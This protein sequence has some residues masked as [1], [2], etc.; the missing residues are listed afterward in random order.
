MQFLELLTFY[1]WAII[2]F[3]FFLLRLFKLDGISIPGTFAGVMMAVVTFIDPDIYW[4]WQVWG[5]V[6]LTAVT[7]I[8]YL[9]Q[10][11]R[12]REQ[13]RDA[14]PTV[15][16]KAAFMVGTTVTLEQPL[17]S[18]IGKLLING[19]YWRVT[20]N[21]DYPAGTIVVV[22][23]HQGAVLTVVTAENPSY[24]ISTHHATGAHKPVSEYQRDTDVESEYGRPDFDAWVLFEAALKAHSK[25]SLVAAYYLL[26]AVRGR[27]LTQARRGLNSYTLALFDEENEGRYADLKHNVYCDAGRYEFYFGRGKWVGARGG[28][29][30]KEMQK[31]E[32]ALATPW[33]NLVRGPAAEE[34]VALALE[35]LRHRN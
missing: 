17:A 21:R 31:L 12:Q 7:A 27:S 23:G 1:H 16:D 18:G 13:A 4:G 20:A 35:A 14:V 9:R 22:T 26:C 6:F 33:A 11:Q 32:A 15:A 25:Q 10:Q 5:F 3:G 29:F 2:A 8:P 34:D 30:R 24:G 28:N 19:K